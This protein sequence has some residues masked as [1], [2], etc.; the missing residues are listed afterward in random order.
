MYK[1]ITLHLTHHLFGAASQYCNTFDPDELC[2]ILTAM[3]AGTDRCFGKYVELCGNLDD[4]LE[5]S[6][7]EGEEG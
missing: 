1:W 4:Y 7:M 6:Y 5:Q 2:I 3:P